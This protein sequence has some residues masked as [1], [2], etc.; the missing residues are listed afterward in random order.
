VKLLSDKVLRPE[1]VE[2][3]RS[4]RAGDAE[5]EQISIFIKSYNYMAGISAL[6]RWRFCGRIMLILKGFS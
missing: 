3:L 1:F 4:E 2:R 6:D 5:P